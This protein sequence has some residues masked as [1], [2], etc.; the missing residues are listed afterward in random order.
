MLGQP[1]EGPGAL[2]EALDQPGFGQQLEMARDARLRLAQDVGEVGDGQLGLGEQRQD[3]QPRVLARRPQRVMHGLK[4][5]LDRSFEPRRH[6]RIRYK[7][8][9]IR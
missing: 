5:Q 3:A 6:V 2:A 1:E 9:F 8:I 4:G 7:D